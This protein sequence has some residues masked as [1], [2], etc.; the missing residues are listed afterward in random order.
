[1]RVRQSGL[2]HRVEGRALGSLSRRTPQKRGLDVLRGRDPRAKHTSARTTCGGGGWSVALGCL[3]TYGG[4]PR[5]RLAK[6]ALGG[7]NDLVG[8][9]DDV[10]L[11]GLGVDEAHRLLLAG[12]AEESRAGAK[13]DRENLQP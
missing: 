1:M 6:A 11:D 12:L 7:A 4:Q 3:A 5:S 8:K 2:R 10:A 13:S 9:E